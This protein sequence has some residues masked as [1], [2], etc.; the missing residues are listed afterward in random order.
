VKEAPKISFGFD[1][2]ERAQV[3]RLYWQAF[4]A[5]LGR[6]MGPDARAIS[7]FETVL[8]PE[9]SLV[10][11]APDGTMLGLAGFKTSQ[12]GLVGGSLA[13]MTQA[14]GW[15]G[16]IWR[17]LLLNVL[18]RKVQPRVFQMDGIFVDQAARGTGVGTALL[19]A[20]AEAARERGL[21][22]VH[23]NVIDINPRARALYE[24]VGFRAVKTEQTG[25]LR[26]VFGFKSA[27]RMVRDVGA[28]KADGPG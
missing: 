8:N 23:L 24:R 3:A 9:F 15:F 2:A 19:Q 20:V 7:F 11:R 6:V 4:G 28:V 26:W 21:A 10:A 18:E 5:K 1:E 25:P 27:T 13:Q 17:G 22:Q 16:A 12:G 14:Y